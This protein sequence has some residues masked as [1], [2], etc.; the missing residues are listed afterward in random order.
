MASRRK[1]ATTIGEIQSDLAR[2]SDHVTELLGDKSD[3]VVDEVKQRVIQLRENI[4]SAIAEVG[5]GGR[6]AVRDAKGNLQ[7]IGDTIEES[8]RERPFTMLAL[9]IGLGVV[10]GTTLRR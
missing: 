5:A 8:V 3:D 1:T 9:A 2:L 7:D 4:D 6:A 10:V